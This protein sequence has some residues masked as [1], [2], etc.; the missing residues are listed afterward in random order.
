Q[1]IGAKLSAIKAAEDRLLF[2]ETMQ[3]NGIP[4]ARGGAAYSIQDAEKL[5]KETGYPLL[6]RASFAMG[7]SGASW[8]YEPSQLPEAIHNAIEESPI[9]QAWLEESVRGW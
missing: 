1:L 7:G 8:V 2:R 4:V 6:V 3:K 5:T 9:H